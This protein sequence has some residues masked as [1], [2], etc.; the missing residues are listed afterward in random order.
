MNRFNECDEQ[1]VPPNPI[2]LPEEALTVLGIEQ[3]KDG[4]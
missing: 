2:D 4:H 3:K 1:L